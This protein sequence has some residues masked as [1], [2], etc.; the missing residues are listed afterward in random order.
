MESNE[1][2]TQNDNNVINASNVSKLE[3]RIKYDSLEDKEQ[4]DRIHT[5][6]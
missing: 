4:K 1:S 5:Q 6:N 2:M 3:S